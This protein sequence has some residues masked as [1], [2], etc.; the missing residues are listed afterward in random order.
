MQSEDGVINLED[1]KKC[2]GGEWK[3]SK[4]SARQ[5][6]E[7][8]S[9]PLSK[10]KISLYKE[11][12]NQP[13]IQK[14]EQDYLNGFLGECGAYNVLSDNGITCSEPDMEIYENPSFDKPDLKIDKY[15]VGEEISQ[16][17]VHIKSVVAY[18]EHDNSWTFQLRNKDGYPGGKDRLY[19]NG[20]VWDVV[21]FT[22]IFREETS[23]IRKVIISSVDDWPHVR[24]N[25]GFDKYKDNWYL[26]GI[27]EFY[28]I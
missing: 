27:K 7:K 6:R 1:L 20:S 24:P 5:I 12:R 14:I 23:G 18:S 26:E 2:V 15:R 22:R 17:S 9:K 28:R 4:E 21:I 11:K 25:L 3:Y 13:N 8:Y 10:I 19:K 16:G